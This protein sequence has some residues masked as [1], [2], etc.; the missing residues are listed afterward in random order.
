MRLAQISR[1]MLED[2]GSWDPVVL[3]GPIAGLLGAEQA[4]S[5]ESWGGLVVDGTR[6]PDSWWMARASPS[7]LRVYHFEHVASPVTL[8]RAGWH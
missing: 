5:L 4:E 3:C 8:I 1:K 2:E 7:S 6:L